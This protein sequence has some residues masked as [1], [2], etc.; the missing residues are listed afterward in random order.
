[1][2]NIHLEHESKEGD[3]IARLQPQEGEKAA[4][5]EESRYKKAAGGEGLAPRCSERAESG[6]ARTAVDRRKALK[7]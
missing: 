2:E 4:K 3:K 5:E 7:D 6:E 1:M